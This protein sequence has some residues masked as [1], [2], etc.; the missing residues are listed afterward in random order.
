MTRGAPGSN[1]G[2]PVDRSLGGRGPPH[3]RA[4]RRP[5]PQPCP[6]AAH[7]VPRRSRSAGPTSPAPPTSPGSRPATWPPSCWP[8]ASSRSWAPRGQRPGRQA[9]HPA[10]DRARRPLRRSPSTSATTSGSARAG[11]PGGQGARPPGR[12][13][14]GSH[15]RRRGRAGPRPR[16]RP[17]RRRRPP[18]LGVGIGSPGVVDPAGVVARG[19]QPRLVRPRPGGR[20]SARGS[21]CRCTWPTTPTPPRSASWASAGRPTAA[22]CSSRSATAS[23]PAWCS[24]ATSSSATGSR[25]ARSATSS[26]TPTASPAPAGARVPRDRDRRAPPAPPAGD[27]AT[28]RGARRRAAGWARRW[29]RSSAR[30]T[31][32]RSCCRARSTCS[33]RRF[34]AA[35]LDAVRARTMPA[36]G[37]H[38]D[39]RL[40]LARRG[41]RPPRRRDARSRPG[42]GR[43]MTSAR[44]RSRGPRPPDVWEDDVRPQKRQAARSGSPG[45]ART[46]RL[47][48]R[49]RRWRR[50]HRLVGSGAS[51]RGARRPTPRPRCACGSTGPTR[52][53]RWSTWRRPSSTSSTRTSRSR[54]SARSGTGWSTG[55]TRSLPTGD[56]P[57]IVE[58]GNTQAQAYEAAG[59]HGRP[60]RRQGRPRRR[61]PGRQPGRGGHLRRQPSTACRYYAGARI[62]VYRK[63]LLEASG[64]RGADDARRVRRGRQEAAGRQRRHAR[65]SRAST[66]RAATGRPRCRSSGTP[67]ATS[68]S[69]TAASGS[70]SS[71]PTSRSPAWSTVQ[72]IMENANAAPADSDD[73]EDYLAFCNG[74]V[75]MLMGP[76]LE[77]R[78][79]HR[80]G[81]LPR[82]VRRRARCL[83]AARQ[84]RPA[85]PRRSSVARTWASRRRA[86]TP[87]WP[88][89][90]LK[91]LTS[92]D[93]P[94]RVRRD[95][96]DPGA[97]VAARRGAGRR[98][99]R[100]RRPQAA[101]VTRFVPSSEY[102]AEVEAGNILHDMG[103]A[104]AGGAD[105][106]D[107]AAP[108][109]RGHRRDPQRLSRSDA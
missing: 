67:A 81:R 26:S 66:S 15:R 90:F 32:A 60:D 25:P 72:D 18:L 88:L 6:G 34:R 52:R 43:R 4:G 102:W 65:T 78:P 11:R 75:G 5:S 51:P 19:A 17:R 92:E 40:Q 89:E 107:E 58:M 37:D 31:C 21:T 53:R 108:R 99:G 49:R 14:R 57:D 1:G 84:R 39:I 76:G 86:R 28:P 69:T 95:R 35:A 44:T 30:S 70:A 33:T 46:G 47:R 22:C 27:G 55:S 71:A 91:V 96:A 93:V 77:D 98:G 104:I 109:R 8:R 83:R 105:V 45:G 62:V 101:E 29:P 54:S 48:V 74:E 80:R 9:R 2:P 106:E 42:A 97:Q 94:D 82:Q 41:R 3:G 63:D 23:A 38:V 50:R 7:V 56:S 59:A 36:V 103:T 68:R 13:A 12:R 100:R 16:R 79:D 73:A 87:A 64:L 61:R 85:S 24:T 20:P 10:R